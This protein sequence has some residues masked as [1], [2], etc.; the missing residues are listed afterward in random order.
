MIIHVY[1]IQGKHGVIRAKPLILVFMHLFDEE[2]KTCLPS[3]P[4]GKYFKK[5]KPTMARLE[6]FKRFRIIRIPTGTGHQWSRWS[7]WTSWNVPCPSDKLCLV[8][9]R[10]LSC[11]KQERKWNL[12][13]SSGANVDVTM[14]Q[15]RIYKW[16]TD[17]YNISKHR[18]MWPAFRSNMENVFHLD[19]LMM[20]I[21]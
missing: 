8:P 6:I 11:S 20:N 2:S 15:Q 3:A 4:P 16:H 18:T 5:N 21:E 14:S 9:G 17:G 19:P 13:A 12:A 10:A 1:F 7:P